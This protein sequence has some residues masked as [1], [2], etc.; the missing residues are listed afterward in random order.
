[1]LLLDLKLG[2]LQAQSLPRLQF[3]DAAIADPA[4]LH[5]VW[6]PASAALHRVAAGEGRGREKSISNVA[7]RSFSPDRSCFFRVM[8]K[9]E[10]F[11]V[12]GD[13]P[14]PRSRLSVKVKI[15][16]LSPAT[17]L[18]KITTALFKNAVTNPKK[19]KNLCRKSSERITQTS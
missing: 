18:R 8:G 1:M 6:Q 9:G 4:F 5:F 15:C 3:L 14:C 16:H 2:R 17:R 13:T 19:K 12:N 7:R 11:P 10:R